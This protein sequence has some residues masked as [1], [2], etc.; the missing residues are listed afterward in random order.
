MLN[1]PPQFPLERRDVVVAT[2]QFMKTAQGAKARFV[3]ALIAQLAAAQGCMRTVSFDK[4]VVRSA[5]MV[6]LA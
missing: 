1:T 4:G 3:D 6:L 5:G 2:L